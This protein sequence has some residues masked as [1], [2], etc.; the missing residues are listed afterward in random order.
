MGRKP[1]VPW[2]LSPISRHEYGGKRGET[3]SEIH[4]PSSENEFPG[5]GS[6]VPGAG[7]FFAEREIVYRGRIL[8]FL[9]REAIFR[10]VNAALRGGKEGE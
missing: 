10:E 9:A 6:G 4:F 1:V 7:N 5:T 8:P 3:R 2:H